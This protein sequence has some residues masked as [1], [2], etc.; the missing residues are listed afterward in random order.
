[1]KVKM[2]ITLLLFNILVF[3]QTY[4]VTINDSVVRKVDNRYSYISDSLYYFT[5]QKQYK[6]EGTWKIYSKNSFKQL[7][8][9]ISFDREGNEVNISKH[10]YFN[11]KL[12]IYEAF[13]ENK[14][15]YNAGELILYDFSGNKLSDTILKND[16][17]TTTLYFENGNPQ[18]IEKTTCSIIKYYYTGDFCNPNKIESKNLSKVIDYFYFAR[19]CKNGQII[20]EYNPNKQN[21]IVEEFDCDGI[22]K[23]KYTLN[24]SFFCGEYIEYYKNKQ[25]KEIG[26]MNTIS[27]DYGYKFI[28]VGKWKYYSE[29]GKLIN[30]IEE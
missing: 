30:E 9:V 3:S 14:C 22:L 23:K 12:K 11:G 16:T 19:F 13:S 17:L 7:L 1:M 4:K 21:Q 18:Q 28:K 15:L 5:I 24:A 29:K 8:A 25:I 6:K 27:T 10:Y 20:N 26:I 2:I